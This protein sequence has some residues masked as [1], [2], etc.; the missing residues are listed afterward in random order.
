MASSEAFATPTGPRL[1]GLWRVRHPTPALRSALVFLWKLLPDGCIQ[2]AA[3]VRRL[4]AD[5][6]ALCASDI[7][8]TV[9]DLGLSALHLILQL[10]DFQQEPGLRPDERGRLYRL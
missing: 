8:L 9:A 5:D 10:W 7:R 3:R 6:L 2:R 1:A 4:R